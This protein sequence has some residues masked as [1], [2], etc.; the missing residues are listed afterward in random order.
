MKN[1]LVPALSSALLLAPG[2]EAQ[3]VQ[4]DPGHL[5][6]VQ[7]PAAERPVLHVVYDV[8]QD[9]IRSVTS[10]PAGAQAIGPTPC[11]DNSSIYLSDTYV[12]SDPGTELLAWGTK[13]CTGGGRLRSVTLL[14]L[15][16]AV[17]VVDGGPGGTLQ[18]ALFRGT[19][20]FGTVGSEI[21]RRTI[22]GLPSGTIVTPTT[23]LTLDFGLEPL[24]LPNGPI[25][26]SFLQLDGDTG[27]V[28]V[29]APDAFLGTIDGLDLYSPGPARPASYVG[30][31]NYASINCH[32]ANM[33]VQLDEI[34][35][36]EVAETTVVPDS[37]LNPVILEEVFPPRVGQL[38]VTRV[39]VPQPGTIGPNPPF[40]VLATTAALRSVPAL[41]PYGE[42]LVDLTTS[43]VPNQLDEG[44]Y[45]RFLAP[46]L[47]LVG[48]EFYTQAAV[49]P[50]AAPSIFL[51]NAL[52]HR[53]GF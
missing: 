50:P 16:E 36:D 2:L 43:L 21:F 27:P 14:Y 20:G 3:T 39:D 28:L 10:L 1:L 7:V 30:T 24:P 51:T 17:D 38:W 47:A 4:P 26:W 9:R 46:D 34:A 31:F 53:I 49:L 48:Y 33:F 41:T 8:H 22:T 15:S 6:R 44:T 12:V 23:Y 37:G 40:T 35:A 52:H 25:G 5:R 13:R 18:F 29:T 45:Y 19:R 11:Y 42:V 32:C